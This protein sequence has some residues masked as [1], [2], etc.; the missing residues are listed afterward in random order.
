M[1][2]S[3]GEKLLQEKF[4]TEKRAQAFYSHQVLNYLNERMR[5]F[6]ACQEMVFIAT[7]DEH[8][9][10]DCSFRAG[11]KGFVEVVNERELRYPEYRGNGVMASLGNLVGNAHV[12]M[13]F[14]D[15]FESKIGLH[16][17]G[18]ARIVEE[19]CYAD[20]ELQKTAEGSRAGSPVEHWVEVKV[21]EA[22]IHCS[23]HIPRLK[24]VPKDIFLGT[25]EAV[26]KGGDYFGVKRAKEQ[27]VKP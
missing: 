26:R 1:L 3:A 10:S 11:P 23:K 18:T 16:V 5:E 25:D 14:I 21:E 24:K 2:G 7:A 19:P 20:P 22:Y 15:F 17:N 12:G 8:G 27:R 4:S 6:I 9:E 13:L